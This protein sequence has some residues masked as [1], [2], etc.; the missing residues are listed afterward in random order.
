MA[1]NE[2]TRTIQ[3]SYEVP[4]GNRI[5]PVAGNNQEG[6]VNE[7][8]EDA[9]EV[10]VLR[11]DGSPF[12]GKV[13]T[14]EATRSDGRLSGNAGEAGTI[15]TTV[16]T[17]SDGFA[18]A[19]LRLGSDAGCGNNR[20]RAE[21]R[22]VNGAVDFFASATG[23]D[24]DQINIGSGGEQV[25]AVT[26]PAPQPLSAWVSDG[27]NGVAGVAVTFTVVDG[28]GTISGGGDYN[29]EVVIVETGATGHA[30]AT[31]I[32]GDEPGN[33]VVLATIEDGSSAGAQFIVIGCA[34]NDSAMKSEDGGSSVGLSVTSLSGQVL[35]N[36]Q[37]PIEAVICTLTVGNSDPIETTTSAD[38][39]FIFHDIQDSG[40]A[41]LSLDGSMAIIPFGAGMRVPNLHYE[42]FILPNVDNV[43]T[44]PVL[45]PL[46]NATND[47][48]YDGTEDVVLTVD[49]IAGL[50]MRV[51]AGSVVL[52]DGTVPSPSDPT[53]LSLNQVHSDDIPM[54]PGDG[55]APP[56]SWTLQ[57]GGA[58]FD[59]PVEI[60]Y[61]NMSGLP[62]G[63]AS[64]FL[65][66]DHDTG[67][68][69]IVASGA[70]SSDGSTIRTAPG[71]G[72][73]VAG[74][75]CNCPPYAVTA[76]C[77]KC[78]VTVS[79]PAA[80]CAGQTVVYTATAVGAGSINWTA[81]GAGG[82]PASGSGNSFSVSFASAG[83]A[84]VTAN[85]TCSGGE[86]TDI[87]GLTV[88]VTDG[89]CGPNVAVPITYDLTTNTL[90]A[91]MSVNATTVIDRTVQSFRA[92]ACA[93]ADAGVWRLRVTSV[94]SPG[95]INIVP[96]PV[97]N[98]PNPATGGNIVNSSGSTGHYC[99]VIADL[100]NY[101]AAVG[102]GKGPGWHV[103]QS[104]IDHEDY[105]WHTEWKT[106]FNGRWTAPGGEAA[107]EALTV[108]MSAH[109]SCESALAALMT[110]ANTTFTQ[111]V[112]GAVTDYM[113]LGDSPGDPPYAAG[114]VALDAM[115][116]AIEAYATGQSWPNCP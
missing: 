94:T 104:T 71:E 5:L 95:T 34:E 26:G 98:T 55:A 21:S 76:D 66:F 91:S 67:Q 6:S 114:Q 16:M 96:T 42:P 9:L 83:T 81:S 105:H 24:P 64:W 11:P 110:Q 68:F 100:A 79:G 107:M 12:A 82:S 89:P 38:G 31:L 29:R 70:V 61:P 25:G 74:W 47:V 19:Y 80:V 17:G 115:V 90:P 35:D 84:T 56:F 15:R 39:I 46:L 30:Q 4:T 62:A 28:G 108:P 40:L 92:L 113:A 102:G 101:N 14:F 2:T 33:N 54:R 65:S 116:T 109:E 58:R 41:G 57:P 78:N 18:R 37:R 59:P 45:L 49:G 53:S 44:R 13:V 32:L 20:V 36:A 69:E 27:C 87:H 75:G 60:T 73:T 88:V 77:E 52:A 8:L 103:T 50:E 99:D 97:A 23:G 43:L 48:H 93:D 106:S 112:T 7:L 10:Q 1:G 111:I 51:K 3:V 72:L 63:A 22:D 85:L 86:L